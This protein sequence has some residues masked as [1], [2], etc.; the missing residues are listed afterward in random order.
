MQKTKWIKLIILVSTAPPTRGG[1]EDL[2][3]PPSGLLYVGGALKKAGYNVKVYHLSSSQIPKITPQL[4]LENPLYVGFSVFTGMQTRLSAKMSMMIKNLSP[5]LPI[6]WGGVHPSLLPQEC[7]K[8]S[9]IDSV[10]IGE[11]EET[12]IELSKAIEFNKNMAEITGIGYKE[13]G[14]IFINKKQNFITEL[15]EYSMDWSLLNIHDYVTNLWGGTRIFHFIT[16]RGC[17]H[18]CGFCYNLEFNKRRWRAHST[19]FVI[20]RMREIK[21]KC[22]INGVV[23]DDDNLFANPKRAIHILEKL[24]EME[25]ICYT[26]EIRVDD[27]TEEI[28]KKLVSLNCKTIFF[29][30]ESGSN[31]VLKLINKNFTRDEILQKIK[32]L[33]N[34]PQIRVST[35]GIIGFPTETKEE[36]KET[37]DLAVN[38]ANIHPNILF[39]LGTYL[40]Y[41]GTS[42][43]GLA[44]EEGFVPPE[45]TEDW[46]VFDVFEKKLNITWLK[47]ASKNDIGDIKKINKYGIMLDNSCIGEN[48]PKMKKILKNLFFKISKFRLKNSFYK[49]PIDIFLYDMFSFIWKTMKK[50]K[51]F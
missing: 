23:F 6:V 13:N 28:L 36:L 46:D 18:H 11:G 17:P 51:N 26:I 31:R 48:Q 25:I 39:N 8:E 2:H 27:I 1:G 30:W 5:D 33:A 40:P 19:E 29:G 10:C 34:F 9:Y 37:I 38:M 32:L 35:A 24:K 21:E 12:I 50:I 42:L 7:L 47:W 22:G 15:D 14:N 4:V 3:R 49:F 20:S 44:R 43:Y 45:K 41:P 16:S